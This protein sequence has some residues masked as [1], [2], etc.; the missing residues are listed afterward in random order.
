M[1]PDPITING[2]SGVVLYMTDDWK[3]VEA[4]KATLAKVIF[5]DG[6]SAFYRVEPAKKGAV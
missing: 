6:G 4:K 3:L 5:D 2:R 1:T